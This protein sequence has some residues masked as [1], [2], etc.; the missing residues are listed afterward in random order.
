MATT[1][2]LLARNAA[3]YPHD[4]FLV[5]GPRKFTFS[6]F[7]SRVLDL[8]EKLASL[9]VGEGSVVVLI[10]TNSV[11][12]VIGLLAS[13]HCGAA[14]LPFPPRSTPAETRD[15]LEQANCSAVLTTPSL[16]EHSHLAG[17]ASEARISPFVITV[18]AVDPKSLEVMITLDGTVRRDQMLNEVLLLMPTSG[19][20]GEPKLV[21]LSEYHLRT[22]AKSFSTAMELKRRTE[23]FYSALPLYHIF[24]MSV[25]LFPALILAGTL[26]VDPD[27]FFVRDFVDGINRHEATL[28]A[29]VPYMARL[30]ADSSL[31]LNLS[32]KSLRYIILSGDNTPEKVVCSLRQHT[33]TIRYVRSYGLTEAAPRVAIAPPRDFSVPEGSVGKPLP[34]VDIR[35]MSES[36]FPQSSG[37]E[38]EIQVRS[39]ST[40]AGYYRNSE[41]TA[42]TVVGEWLK[43]GDM[44]FLDDLGY[45]FV[46]G[47]KKN[48][49][50][51]GGENISPEEVESVLLSIPGIHEAVVVGKPD[52]LLGEVPVALVAADA[53]FSL[54]DVRRYCRTHLS[55]LK[56]PVDFI[57]INSIPRLA[58]GKIDRVRLRREYSE[59]RT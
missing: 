36:G 51:R 20:T 38:G 21:M 56:L 37:Q 34:G 15:I 32:G 9:G 7:R 17:V 25:H 44:G 48:I 42:E 43:T 6:D 40:M 49:I 1:I 58:N 11:E 12:F 24:A 47:R 39:P 29:C 57:C 26:I 18:R 8:G 23:V 52:P 59:I 45:L 54:P 22:N 4:L 13:H 46:S 31:T 35:I 3:E 53:D 19:T 14:V 10:M 50:I 55:S 16:L 5:E 28:T 30:L 2:E 33:S 27:P 41:L